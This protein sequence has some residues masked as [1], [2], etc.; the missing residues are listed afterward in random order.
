[1]PG[2]HFD[3]AQ[4]YSRQTVL[5][6]LGKQGQD[7][8]RKAKAAV[9]GV[10]GIGTVSALYLALAGVRNLILVDQDTVELHNLHRQILFTARDLRLPK[11]ELAARRLME[12]NPDV[13]AL[14]VPDNLREANVEEIM[15]KADVVVDGL[16]NMKTRYVV[17]SVCSRLH[18]PY[19]FGG[20]IAMEGNISVFHPPETP[21]LECILPSID[22][23][24]LPG[25]DTR[26]VLGATAAIVGAIQAMEAIKLLAGMD[27]TLKGKLLVCDFRRMEFDKIEIFRR[28]DCSVCGDEARLK[29]ERIERL[30]WLCGRETMNVNPPEPTNLDLEK[31]LQ[32]LRRRYDVLARS[33]VVIVFRYGSHEVSLFRNGRMLIKEVASEEEALRTYRDLSKLFVRRKL[34]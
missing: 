22:D 1:M 4:Y 23:A 17:N 5:K 21:C 31:T 14:G 10:G 15:K 32:K 28:E 29:P 27:E 30:A 6:E 19:V 26:G 8:L 3:P 12:A 18:I 2:A 13:K 9:I 11:A 7:R 34:R 24:S 16:D 25:C 33:S 20:A